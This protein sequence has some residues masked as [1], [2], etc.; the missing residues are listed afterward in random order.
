MKKWR[1][2]KSRS[3][4]C[5]EIYARGAYAECP[6]AQIYSFPGYKSM[7]WSTFPQL[8]EKCEKFYFPLE[9]IYFI[10]G[11]VAESFPYIYKKK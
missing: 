3:R 6:G 1:K 10:K 8:I 2:K 5:H 11:K 4:L 9:R 7:L